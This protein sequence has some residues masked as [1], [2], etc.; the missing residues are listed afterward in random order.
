MAKKLVEEKEKIIE[1]GLKQRLRDIEA[2]KAKKMMDIALKIDTNK[3]IDKRY[4]ETKKAIEESG[5][6]VLS[7]RSISQSGA[8]SE[9]VNK[10]KVQ[11]ASPQKQGRPS[12]EERSRYSNSKSN[13]EES[14]DESISIN[15]SVPSMHQSVP[16]A[17]S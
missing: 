3:E 14:I 17:V 1:A 13:V 9:S 8:P 6:T 10:R 12:E 15:E 4:K 16:A 11:F 7:A 2:E 5:E